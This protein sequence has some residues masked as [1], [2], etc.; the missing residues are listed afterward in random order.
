M[1]HRVPYQGTVVPSLDEQSIDDRR[2][3]SSRNA[4]LS[5]SFVAPYVLRFQADPRTNESRPDSANRSVPNCR[6]TLLRR[7]PGACQLPCRH[8]ERKYPHQRELGLFTAADTRECG[9]AGLPLDR[10]QDPAQ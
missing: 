9:K 6:Q 7:K 4:D 3:L 1:R 2:S 8:S 10:Y 5:L